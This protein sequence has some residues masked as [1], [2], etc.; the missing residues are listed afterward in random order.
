VRKIFVI[1]GLISGSITILGLV[2]PS[3]IEFI[4]FRAV[5]GIGLGIY[6]PALVAIVS[7][8]G[9][10]IGNFSAYGSFGWAVGVLISGIIGLYWVPAIFIFG[11]LSLLGAAMVAINVKEEEAS[12]K[13][14]DSYFSVFWERKRIYLALAIRHSFAAAIWTFWPLF[15]LNLGANTFWIAII[16]CT[17]ALTQTIIMNKFTDKMKNQ[18]M[19]SLGLFLSCLSFISFTIPTNFIGIIPTQVILGLSWAFLYVG[20]LRSSIEKSHF[21]KSTAAGI[22][23]SVL[24]VANIIGSLIALM[25]TSYGGSYLEIIILAA[26]ATFITFIVFTFFENKS[27][28]FSV[29]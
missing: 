22:I 14:Q 11:A 3:K 29:Q 1:I 4:F 10:K 17:N 21:D 2:I 23:T 9:D 19:V 28:I 5:S 13:Y 12:K 20:T 7:D 24:P 16:Q 15:L 27:R 25:I 6:S 26:F 8:K 18:H